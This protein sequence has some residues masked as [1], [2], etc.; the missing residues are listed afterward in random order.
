M[1]RIG[2]KPINVPQGI[3]VTILSDKVEVEGP[4]GKES[5][6]LF[7]GL[8]V[9]MEDNIITLDRDEKN[10]DSGSRE[11]KKLKA[12]HGLSRSLISNC[13]IGTSD[14][15]EKALEIKGVGYR[16]QQKGKDVQFQLGYS[17]DIVFNVPE[18]VVVTVKSPT[19]LLVSGSNKERVGQVAADIRSLRKPEPYKGKGIRYKDEHIIMKA[20]KVGKK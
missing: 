4:K 10:L 7:P 12:L 2:F 3:K 17:H 15:F 5:A 14:G 19:E 6:P 13:I 11:T 20:G 8:I 18:G 1:S 16:A 9:K